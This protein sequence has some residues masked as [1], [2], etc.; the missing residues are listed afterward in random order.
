VVLRRSRRQTRREM[1]DLFEAVSFRCF[2]ALFLSALG[3]APR[4]H[5]SVIQISNLSDPIFGATYQSGTAKIDSFGGLSD[6]TKL[7]SITDGV[8]VVGFPMPSPRKRSLPLFQLGVCLQIRN[9]LRQPSSIP[10]RARIQVS[11]L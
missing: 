9:R 1:L 8:L 3:L 10:S 5:A 4:L 6:L 7:N 11:A 2:A